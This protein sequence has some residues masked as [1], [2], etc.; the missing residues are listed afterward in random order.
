VQSCR[1]PWC[2]A[3]TEPEAAFCR[4]HQRNPR[5]A[6]LPVDVQSGLWS[7]EFEREE[8]DTCSGSGEHECADY[9]CSVTHE[10]GACDG[11][12]EVETWTAT[13]RDTLEVREFDREAFMRVFPG[14]DPD[15]VAHERA[16]VEVQATEMASLLL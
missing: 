9:R 8:C 3:L 13:N 4:V 5:F 12:G 2:V 15:V 11:E 6:P 7:F 1:I 16:P 10:C 14:V